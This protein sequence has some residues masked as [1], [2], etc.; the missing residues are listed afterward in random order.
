MHKYQNYNNNMYNFLCFTHQLHPILFMAR[1]L[2]KNSCVD[3]SI[4]APL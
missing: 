1:A 2:K 4:P 3:E